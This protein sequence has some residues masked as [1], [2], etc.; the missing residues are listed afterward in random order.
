MTRCPSRKPRIPPLEGPK[1]ANTRQTNMSELRLK[2]INELIN[3]H[4]RTEQE[5]KELKYAYR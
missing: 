2:R 5:E 3:L 1:L 4:D